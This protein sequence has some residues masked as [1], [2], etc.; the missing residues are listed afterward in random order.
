[1]AMADVESRVSA[2]KF[3]ESVRVVLFRAADV[4][5]RTV[6]EPALISELEQLI[7]DAKFLVGLRRTVTTRPQI[8]ALAPPTLD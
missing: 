3:A 4:A 8:D 2:N 1:M 5:A 6:D 7:E